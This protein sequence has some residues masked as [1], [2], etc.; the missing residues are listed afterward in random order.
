MLEK[1]GKAM[2]NFIRMFVDYDKNNNSSFWHQYMR[3]RVRVD[4]RLSLKKTKV[5]NKGG[6]WCT[7]NF[8]YEKLSLFSFVY[9]I[10]GHSEQ[11]CEIHFATN[12]DN[13]VRWRSNETKA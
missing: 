1:V 13:R 3:L 10:L 7:V 11:R 12:E 9:G 5:K 6:D 4:V 8:K 2:E